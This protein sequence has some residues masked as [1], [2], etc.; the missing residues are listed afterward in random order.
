[1]QAHQ[2]C[3]HP[4]LHDHILSICA[5][6]QLERSGSVHAERLKNIKVLNQL[7]SSIECE[8][9]LLVRVKRYL[10]QSI[11]TARSGWSGYLFRRRFSEFES[12]IQTG[13]NC[14]EV[15]CQKQVLL[16]HIN[17]LNHHQTQMKTD[18]DQEIQDLKKK[19]EES[20]NDLRLLIQD[21]RKEISECKK[22]LHHQPDQSDLIFRLQT[23]I[24]RLR[25]GELESDQSQLMLMPPPPMQSELNP[26]KHSG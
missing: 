19:H 26:L 10:S 16:E 20:T 8:Q 15:S 13:L 14:Y 17:T 6:Y 21:L 11:Q 2:C 22:L 5:L 25:R 23:E 9:L 1:M 4:S 3:K 24:L 12:M 7:C 18:H